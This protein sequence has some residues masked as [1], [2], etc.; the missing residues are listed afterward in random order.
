MGYDDVSWGYI[1]GFHQRTLDF[2][3]SMALAS[4]LI[5]MSHVC[6]T[7][8]LPK[9]VFSMRVQHFRRKISQ[10]H[11]IFLNLESL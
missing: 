10:Q 3:L 4:A 1:M 8:S 5:N 2:N 11:H 6:M 9:T 7:M